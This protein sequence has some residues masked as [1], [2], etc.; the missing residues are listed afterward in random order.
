MI[1]RITS[2]L[3]V[4]CTLFALGVPG[5]ATE[6]ALD[7]P[8]AVVQSVEAP[9]QTEQAETDPTEAEPTETEPVEVEPTETEPTEAEPTEAEPAETFVPEA[10]GRYTL[11]APM[12]AAL[13]TSAT[14][15]NGLV[16]NKTAVSNG[17]GGYTITLESYLLG[18]VT[19]SETVVPTDIVLVLDESGSMKD[20]LSYTP[21]YFAQAPTSG[22]YYYQ[23]NNGYSQLHYCD[24]SNCKGW[25]KTRHGRNDHNGTKQVPKTSETDTSSERLQF[26]AATSK[27]DA[28]KAAASAFVESVAAQAATN[29]VEHRV[30]VVGFSNNNAAQTYVGLVNTITSNKTTVLGA[31]S[32]LNANGGTYIEDGMAAAEAVFSG[33][34]APATSGARNKVVV[35]FTDGVPGNGSWSD[36]TINNSAGPAIASALTMKTA[37]TTV[38]TIGMLTGADPTA[39]ISGDGD[40]ARTNR[41]LHY[42]SS[43]YPAAQSMADGKTGKNDGYYL[44]ANSSDSL[45]EIFQKISES[46][47]TPTLN[48]GAEAVMRD[49][50]SPY[51][52]IPANATATA[53]VYPCTGYNAQTKL[54]SWGASTASLVPTV[55][56]T[57]GAVEV[58][59]FDYAT[60][61]VTETSKST[62]SSNFGSK[63]VVT[64]TV[65]PKDG[66]L[67]GNAVPTNTADSGIY[68]ADSFFNAFPQPTVDVPLGALT[69]TAPDYNVYLLGSLSAETLAA[70]VAFGSFTWQDDYVTLT[71]SV[72]A[73]LA[74]LTADTNY[75]ATVTLSPLYEGS[76]IE[77]RLFEASGAVLVFKPVL[78]FRDGSAFYGE[79]ASFGTAQNLVATAWKHG[80]TASA[81]V[82]MTGTVP[83]LTLGYTASAAT[84]P[85]AQK[86]DIPVA[87]DTKIGAI[88][89]TAHTTLLHQPCADGCSFV[90]TASTPFC[91][92][93]ATGQLT[94]TKQ[95]GKDGEPYVF[96]ILRNNTPYTTV[97]ITGNGSVTLKE[98]PS[99]SYTIAEDTAFSWRYADP[100]PSISPTANVLS[101]TNPAVG[102]VCTNTDRTDSWL[103]GYSAIAKNVFTKGGDPA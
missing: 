46:I 32:G 63:L 15:E 93:V 70:G 30:A 4:V 33:A 31:I 80:T 62:T 10:L 50:V 12:L 7:A 24:N 99:G 43:N 57:T 28:L 2:G 14:P 27:S 103:N 100:A 23:N 11:V 49:F 83:S 84:A 97:T 64:F 26:Y 67:G 77:S 96:E 34:S 51:F 82:T 45:N 91:L 25:Y 42:L 89:V 18:N 71:P 58:S 35:V 17:N 6:P 92:H 48:L 13:P 79:T 85:V 21:V 95:G 98:L 37:G 54:Y 101:S 20:A 61:C 66:F 94:I 5:Y 90:P 65:V 36:N 59:G 87:V 75:P 38:Y 47:T 3:L 69:V 53:A 60:N 41:F 29:S 78:T 72:S 39:S 52:T 68:G 102:F 55:N 1:K 76:S 19:S 8:D 81:S 40:T 9:A 88:D 44:A 22:T 86:A 73:G 74:D 16:L 56:K